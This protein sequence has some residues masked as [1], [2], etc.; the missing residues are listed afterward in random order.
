MPQEASTR[1]RLLES[2]PIAIA[3]T[4]VVLLFLIGGFVIMRRAGR[5]PQ[6]G[7]VTWNT[8][9][10]PLQNPTA[11]PSSYENGTMPTPLSGT[12][13]DT[14]QL[15][16]ASSS[17]A[18]PASASDA[19]FESFLTGLLGSPAPATPA[20]PE[21]RA[22]SPE[23]LSAFFYIPQGLI[24]TS[25]EK[26]RTPAQEALH[27]YGN[28]AGALI[29][30]FEASH[31]DMVA[32]LSS[33]T[34]DRTSA[35]G[36][37]G[38]K[39]LAA[40]LGAIGSDMLKLE[41]VPEEARAAHEALARKYEEIG[42]KLALIADTTEDKDYLAAIETY[43][44]AADEFTRSYSAIMAVFSLAGVT[45]GAHEGGSAFVFTGAGGF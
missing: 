40:E 7:S 15:P 38:M 43:N 32:T 35:S 16:A 42:K 6:Q 29:K 18:A 41:G 24:G 4:V 10:G 39:A 22:F 13:P 11:L 37:A 23:T 25:R 28:A 14:V 27:T 2:H 3:I 17:P 44:A 21:T 19:G 26:P 33:F 45:F 20:L 9:G 34:L 30:Q 1:T 5:E 12:A 31:T 36:A 8:E